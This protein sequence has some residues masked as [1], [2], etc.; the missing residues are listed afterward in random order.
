MEPLVQLETQFF[1]FQDLVNGFFLEKESLF[2]L[3]A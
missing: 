2:Q 1:T 3:H